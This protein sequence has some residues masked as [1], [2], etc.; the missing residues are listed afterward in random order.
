MVVGPRG[1]FGA[2]LLLGR[3]SCW[4]TDASGVVPGVNW[5]TEEGGKRELQGW[6]CR[7]KAL[8]SA[9]AGSGRCL[10]HSSVIPQK[11]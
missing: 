8:T 9:V 11:W 5:E 3:R 6:S 10:P 7:G 1:N 4:G 2:I